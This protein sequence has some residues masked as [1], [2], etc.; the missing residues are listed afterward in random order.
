MS[1]TNCLLFL[2]IFI[3][4]IFT[5]IYQLDILPPSLNWDEISHSYNA[6]SLLKTGQDQWGISWPIFNFRAYGDYP[7]TLNLYLSMPFIALFGLNAMT[8]R[9]PTAICGLLIVIFTYLIAKYF[10]KNTRLALITM[11]ITAVAPWTIFTSRAAYQSTIAQAFFLISV[12]LLLVK[13]SSWGLFILAL[14][15]FGYHNTRIIALPIAIA[16]LF[17]LRPPKSFYRQ[18]IPILF[19]FLLCSASL[20][21]FFSPDSR[22]RQ[23]WVGILNPAAIN[24]INENRRTFAGPPLIN[25]LVNNK[26]TYFIPSFTSNFLNLVNPIPLFLIGSKQF[27]F[28]VA[29][30]GL[31]YLSWLPFFYLGL[32]L[33]L[34]RQNKQPNYQFLLAWYLIGLIPSALTTGDFPTLRSFTIIPLPFIAIV[35]GLKKIIDLIKNNYLYL[36]FIGITILELVNY[37]QKYQKYSQN[38]SLSWQYGYRQAVDYA[39]DNYQNYSQIYFTKKYGEPH[40]F[41]L[42]FWPWDPQTYQADPDKKWDYHSGWYWVDSFDK[43]RFINDWE[44]KT[45]DLLPGSLL[46]TSP[47]NYPPGSIKLNTIYTP[48]QKPIFDLVRL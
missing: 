12:W 16:Y 18:T 36:I 5:R 44:V 47:D 13:K 14:S 42:F 24:L 40:E 9:L 32:I 4:A 37:G 39:K 35:I 34:I 11:F 46:I 38:Y 43:F 29:N 3:L 45:T 15:M 23:Q 30:S 1:K 17:I 10:F 48:D 20:L 2:A 22:A 28:N 25:R 41:L 27:Q 26:I 31:L 8:T 19:A 21:N 6:Y 7:T 33:I